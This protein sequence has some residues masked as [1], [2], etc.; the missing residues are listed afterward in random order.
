MFKYVIMMS[1][2]M[3]IMYLMKCLSWLGLNRS[4]Y[5]LSFAW[6]VFLCVIH[7]SGSF[8]K[9]WAVVSKLALKKC[10]RSRDHRHRT[11]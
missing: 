1:N 9:F 5:F 11:G 10:P 7:C 6:K 3:F 4:C 2:Y 8:I